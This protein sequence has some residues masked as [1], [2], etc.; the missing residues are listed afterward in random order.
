MSYLNEKKPTD[1][2]VGKILKYS[3]IDNDS[4]W[5][6]VGMGDELE[7]HDLPRI[8]KDVHPNGVFYDFIFYPK[9]NGS[10]SHKLFFISRWR[11]SNKQKT[12]TLSPNYLRKYF[13]TVFEHKHFQKE[14]K[15]IEVTVIPDSNAL[16]EIFSLE[17]IN[18]LDL[19]IKTPNPDIF[20][21]DFEENTL[22]R[23]RE[24]NISKVHETYT[25]DGESIEPDD[26]LKARAHIAQNNGY[27]KATGVNSHGE[28][29]TLS[30]VD[31]PMKY[32]Q[33]VDGEKI[34]SIKV[35][36]RNFVDIFKNLF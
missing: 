25:F 36:L 31:I 22:N 34:D 8:P 10:A 14:F 1:G 2:I 11:D 27:V 26:M 28:N 15:S 30:T 17:T 32:S 16:E 18:K 5:V 23:H 9:S 12:R 7:E 35:A 4:A 20:D 29:Q 21:E 24:M 19:E 3:H 33:K 13:E 6:N